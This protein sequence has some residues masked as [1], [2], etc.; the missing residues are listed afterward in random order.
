[1]NSRRFSLHATRQTLVAW[2]VFAVASVLLLKYTQLAV[3]SLISSGAQLYRVFGSYRASGWAAMHHLDP[4]AVYPLTWRFQ[5]LPDGPI[6][7]DRNLSPPCMLPLFQAWAHL[8]PRTGAAVWTTVSAALFII[9]TALLLLSARGKMQKRQIVW[10]LL[11]PAVTDT[12]WLGQDYALFFFLAYL[13]WLLM[14]SREN[15]A[16]GICLGLLI[17]L[18][19]NLGLWP[20]ML[21]LSGYRKDAVVSISTALGFSLLPLYLYGPS[22]YPQWLH[23]ASAV[24]HYI[25]PTDISLMG[26]CSRL[27][28]RHTGAFLAI[29]MASALL[30]FVRR[31]RPS[32][33]AISGIAV[34]TGILCAP[35]GWF[36]YVL[37]AA[38]VF[39]SYKWGKL[40]TSAAILL[41][42]PPIFLITAMGHGRFLVFLSAMPYFIGVCLMLISFMQS[43][44]KV[45]PTMEAAV[46][47]RPLMVS[48]M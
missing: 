29:A 11:M 15:L 25:F 31:T 23:A 4:Y 1:M 44:V 6:I 33:V 38:P 17:A 45:R 39:T 47:P 8:T 37:L 21:F 3:R 35:L 24:P 22:I 12:L 16:A 42:T 32:A 19:P 28:S 43:A 7:Y 30:L 10:L 27:G 41:F 40:K 48:W 2:S 20:I 36:H 34:C 13:F 46:S 9:G 14:K 18:K 5:P 26:I